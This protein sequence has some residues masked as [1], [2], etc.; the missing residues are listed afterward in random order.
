MA[1]CLNNLRILVVDDEADQRLVLKK[2]LEKN[3]YFVEVA[4]NGTEALKRI[5]EFQFDL[6]L[7]DLIM[8]NMNGVKLLEK[9]KLFDRSIEV[10]LVTG[11][12]SIENAV[13]AMKKGA[14]SYFVKSH[15]PKELLE[16]IKKVELKI[17]SSNSCEEFS[18]ISENFI[19][20]SKNEK[21][22]G[23]LSRIKRAAQSN[24]NILLLGES[25]VGKEIIARYIHSYS[26]N[27][28]EKFVAVNCSSFYTGLLE[29]ELFGYE[30]GAFTGANESRK[31]RFEIANKGTLFLDEIG[32]TSLETQVKLLRVIDNKI[33]EKIGSNKPVKVDFRLISATNKD[34]SQEVINSKFREDFFYRI[35]TIII[36][37]PPLRERNE[38]LED[39][40]EF[41]FKKSLEKFNRNVKGISKE[42][43]EFLLNYE[44]KGNIRE[45]KNIIERIV[46]LCDSE[47][48]SLRDLDIYSLKNS[49]D[50]TS[51]EEDIAIC[52]IKFLKD[53]RREVESKYIKRVIEICDNNISEAARRL[54][55]SRRQLFNKIC[56]YEI[57]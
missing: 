41:F 9:I 32:D 52:D 55:I 51:L 14:F 34:L 10:I 36:R 54:G 22:Q 48:I 15:D 57:R 4:K 5:K 21:F 12:G 43:M 47:Y 30:K 38:D 24:I 49:K 18:A 7:T 20:A 42:A 56:E 53:M 33:I 19:L 46:V 45:L 27:K 26:E 23:T 11:Y 8:E 40:I 35:S 44:Y 16:E 29:S 3:G 17:T 50:E 2:I 1:N 31:G 37:I 25:G 6:V 39:F 13:E 28:N